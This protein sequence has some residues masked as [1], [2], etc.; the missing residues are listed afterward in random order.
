[1]RGI[2]MCM[3]LI[4]CM[5]IVFAQVEEVPATRSES[6]APSLEDTKSE[7][8]T[9]EPSADL[10]PAGQEDLSESGVRHMRDFV[11]INFMII[12]IVILIVALALFF[13]IKRV[14][15]SKRL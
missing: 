13:I 8:E 9:I 6:V 4:A 10:D 1:M 2:G 11:T 14:R 15:R 12:I 7:S 5:M 3:V